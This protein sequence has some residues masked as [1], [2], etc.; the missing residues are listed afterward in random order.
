MDQAQKSPRWLTGI[1]Y[2]LLK[3][4]PFFDLNWLLLTDIDRL[5]FSIL[6][7][8]HPVVLIKL[9]DNEISSVVCFLLGN[10]P[11]SEVYV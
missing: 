7:R 8:G 9:K 5:I 2:T 1:Y 10:S 4:N 11:A 6:C 3:R